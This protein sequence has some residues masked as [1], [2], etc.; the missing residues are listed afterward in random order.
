MAVVKVPITR[1]I[2]GHKSVREALRDTCLALA[3]RLEQRMYGPGDNALAPPGDQTRRSV[4]LRVKRNDLDPLLAAFDAPVPSGPTGR[5]D[6]TN[7]PG[8]S[9][10]LLND[11]FVRELAD[12]W[13]HRLAQDPA[14]ADAPTRIRAMFLQALA[15]PPTAAELE[16]SQRFVAWAATPDSPTPAGQSAAAP[17]PWADLAHALFNLKEFIFIP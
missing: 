3:G 15:R 14:L 8:Q 16:R 1:E 5:R 17:A 12:H 9:L 2:R 7:V 11:P 6:V 13:A 4:Y 10:T